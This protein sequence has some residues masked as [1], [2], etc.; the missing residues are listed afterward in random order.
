[1]K[2]CN[3]KGSFIHSLCLKISIKRN[4]PEYMHVNISPRA[5]RDLWGLGKHSLKRQR[6]KHKEFTDTTNA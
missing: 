3:K 2:F 1:M 6:T 4:L 5:A